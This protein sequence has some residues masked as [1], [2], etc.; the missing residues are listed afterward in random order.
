MVGV[1]AA[2]AQLS[3]SG[4]SWK[5]EDNPSAMGDGSGFYQQAKTCGGVA[6]CSVGDNFYYKGAPPPKNPCAGAAPKKGAWA[7]KYLVGYQ[8]CQPTPQ[9]DGSSVQCGGTFAPSAPPIQNEWSSWWTQG[10]WTPSGNVCGVG[11]GGN[12][13][14]WTDA[15]GKPADPAPPPAGTE[16]PKDTP[17]KTCGD[18]SCYD[19]SK[20]QYCAQGSSGQ[21]CTTGAPPAPASGGSCTSGGDTTVCSG[22]PQAPAPP[23]TKVPDPPTATQ[24]TDKYTTADPKTGNVYNN[25]TTVYN[26]GAGSTSSGAGAGDSS[27][28]NPSKGSSTGGGSGTGTG[29]G[30]TGG[31]GGTGTGTG[32]TGTGTG[33]GDKDDGDKTGASGGGDCNN[34]PSVTGSP[35]LGMVA[36]QAW[37]T[38]C[39]TEKVSKGVDALGKSVDKV[40][41]VVTGTGDPGDITT[42]SGQSAWTATPSSGDAVA[43]AANKGN[44]DGTGMGF[45]STCPM[46]DLEVPLWGGNTFV[47]P[48]SRG[49]PI[50][51]W[52]KALVIAFA[53]FA[54]AKI[55]SGANG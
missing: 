46:R 10:T 39:Q 43:D 28:S 30:S 33:G 25:T 14:D 35:A 5:C 18:V 29:S 2:N 7:G 24:G 36:T 21:V 11:A 4:D 55:T 37:Q 9:S 19:P 13:A 41:G 50:G 52:I 49:C 53:L 32:G 27:P 42:P 31:T 48:I 51:A 1:N 12:G 8:A 23:A 44:Y 38:R 34:P 40:V 15:A 6:H 54:A 3:G 26:N 47:V 22:S 20:G 16:P 45:S 17:P